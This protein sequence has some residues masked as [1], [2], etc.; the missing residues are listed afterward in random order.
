MITVGGST[1]DPPMSVPIKKCF[2]S[3]LASYNPENREK[4][5]VLTLTRAVGTGICRGDKSQP[6]TATTLGTTPSLFLGKRILNEYAAP[7]NRDSGQQRFSG[8][9]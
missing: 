8:S 4:V 9:L 3:A 2:P 6:R 7:S 5:S 1:F